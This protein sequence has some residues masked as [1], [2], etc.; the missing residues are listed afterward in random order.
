MNNNNNKFKSLLNILSLRLMSRRREL[1]L[2]QEEIA[3]KSN[4]SLRSYQRIESGTHTPNLNSLHKISRTLLLPIEE[5]FKL[6]KQEHGIFQ[7]K[8]EH[9]SKLDSLELKELCIF[10]HHTIKKFYKTIE[11]FERMKFEIN[12]MKNH[13]LLTH[14]DC[15]NLAT[16]D[17]NILCNGTRDKL[18]Y[19]NNKVETSKLLG[20]RQIADA[21][22]DELLKSGNRLFSIET[23]LFTP[24]GQIKA[25]S[26]FYLIDETNKDPKGIWI[27]RDISQYQ[28]LFNKI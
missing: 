24:L 12:F 3:F 16:P 26:L 20:S 27:Y 28:T 6:E 7:F 18:G 22:W 10:D 8:I 2:T 11:I 21:F 23:N 1:K 14:D 15:V 4:I 5:L 13:K 19:D 25:R 9:L 17:F